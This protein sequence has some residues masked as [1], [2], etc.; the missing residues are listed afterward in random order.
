VRRWC[1][2]TPMGDSWDHQVDEVSI[3]D[4]PKGWRDYTVAETALF[5]R[6][7]PDGAVP[8]LSRATHELVKVKRI[9][10]RRPAASVGGGAR[11]VGGQARGQGG[12]AVV[13]IRVAR[14]RRDAAR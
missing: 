11:G 2:D 5:D 7:R 10:N 3:A 4:V 14:L 8:T 9:Q 6:P 12:G 1:R 13:R